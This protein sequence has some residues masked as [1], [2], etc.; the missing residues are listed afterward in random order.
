MGTGTSRRGL[1]LAALTLGLAGLT[2]A[3]AGCGGA[4]SGGARRAATAGG[5]FSWV[6]PQPPPSSWKLAAIPSGAAMAYP[7]TWEPQRGD[8][9]TATAALMGAGGQTLGYLNL[10]PRQGSETLASWNSFRVDHNADEGDK[11]VERLAAAQHLRFR[12]GSGSCVKDAYTTITDARYVEVACLVAGRR[13]E[14]VIVA[15]APP[16]SW[17]RESATLERAVEGVRT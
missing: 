5:A 1:A 13:G 11:H 7:S 3:L 16:G 10:T 2:P 14:A 12:D 15:A 8:P 4:A 9:G 17:G 6:H